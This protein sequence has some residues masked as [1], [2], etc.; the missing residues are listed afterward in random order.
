MSSGFCVTKEHAHALGADQ[1]HDLFDLF[2]QGRRCIVEE[3]MCFIEEKHQLG[4]V[5]VAGLRQLFEQF[6]QQPQQ[7]GGVEARIVHQLFG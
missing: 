7:K 4:F 3:Q 6:G 1:A 5:Q 2:Q